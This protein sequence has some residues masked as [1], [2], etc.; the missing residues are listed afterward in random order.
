[1]SD[2]ESCEGSRGERRNATSSA[3]LHGARAVH[4]LAAFY[5]RE[6]VLTADGWVPTSPA[7]VARDRGY[8]L[9]AATSFGSL[10]RTSLD[11]AATLGDSWRYLSPTVRRASSD[12][13]HTMGRVG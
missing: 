12:V 11:A 1:M 8:L 3:A 5:V 9:T 13:V 2:L 6:L 4:S 10:V 7:I